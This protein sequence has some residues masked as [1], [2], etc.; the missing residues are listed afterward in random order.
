MPRFPQAAPD[1]AAELRWHAH[2]LHAVA[3]WDSRYR[4][5]FIPQGTLYEFGLGVAA[6]TRDHAMHALPCCRY[7]PDLARSVLSYLARH[8][9]LLGR[10]Q[11]TDEGAGLVPLGC[12]QKS[13]SQL[14]ALLLCVEYLEQTADRAAL[15]E[16]EPFFPCGSADRGSL[17]ER[18]GLWLRYLRDG[19]HVGTHGLVRICYSDISDT[20]H[21]AFADLPYARVFNGESHVNTGMAVHVLD[22]LGLV[23][24]ASGAADPRCQAIIR[25]AQDLADQLRQALDR[26]L[27]GRPWCPRGRCGD[28]VLGADD[29]F[30]AAQSFLL[31]DDARD[32]AW[33]QALWRRIRPAVW[34]G[35]RFG[36]RLRSG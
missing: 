18:I 33:R 5:T 24:A 4:C 19:I 10:I 31:G 3:T 2:V 9:D 29:V 11:F 15:Q 17:L 12:D 14:F 20:L 6:V 22:R 13:D 21:Q 1:L 35:E 16:Q 8:T 7:D 23:L 34:D 32:H 36:V 30:S 28:Q 27:D 25:A 26:D